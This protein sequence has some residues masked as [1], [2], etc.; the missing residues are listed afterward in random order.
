MLKGGATPLTGCMTVDFWLS[1]DDGVHQLAGYQHRDVQV[2]GQEFAAVFVELGHDGRP[3]DQTQRN[4]AEKIGKKDHSLSRLAALLGENPLFH[5]YLAQTA[6][7]DID[8]GGEPIRVGWEY[9]AAG[10]RAAA[11]VRVTCEVN[12]RG[13][14][15]RDDEAAVRFHERVRKPYLAW[16][17]ANG[18][19]DRV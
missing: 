15:D 14:F 4:Q 19:E 16:C 8:D 12:S 11:W 5:E 13:D 1:E 17:A 3:I 2:P 18:Y 6:F 10:N 9:W 7:P